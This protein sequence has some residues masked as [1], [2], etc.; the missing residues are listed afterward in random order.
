MTERS[1]EPGPVPADDE[2]KLDKLKEA[3]R[4]LVDSA[5]DRLVD[6]PLEP[7]ITHENKKHKDEHH[8]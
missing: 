1:G 4:H 7:P 2:S 3:A 5:L 8:D 6:G